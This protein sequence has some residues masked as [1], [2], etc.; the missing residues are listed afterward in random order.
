MLATKLDLLHL[1]R[2]S[3]VPT[4]SLLDGGFS[5]DYGGMNVP[6][7]TRQ[8]ISRKALAERWNV[9]T[10]TIKRYER[11]QILTAIKIAPR[12]LRYDLTEV[13]ALE[14]GG[15]MERAG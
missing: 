13:E 14:E 7:P 2:I 15:R 4:V 8:L 9:S 5:R 1:E 10:E 12:L 3:F 11:K 6:N